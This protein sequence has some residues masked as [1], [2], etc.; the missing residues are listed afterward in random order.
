ME[1]CIPAILGAGVAANNTGNGWVG[2]LTELCSDKGYWFTSLCDIE[3]TF[4][5]PT[6]LARKQELSLSPYP[7]N[8]SSQQA[9]YFIE[10]VENI[11]IGDWIL[12]FNGE[13]VIGARQWQGNIID[14]PAMGDD[15]SDFTHGYIQTGSIP[16]FKLLNGDKLIDLTGDVPTWSENQIFMVSNLTPVP[17]SFKLS[18][19]Y[20]NPF[21]PTTTLSFALPL[22]SK[23]S[24]SIYDLQGREVSMLISGN[25]H[26]GYHSVVWDANSYASGMYFVKMVSGEFVKTQ[27]LMLVK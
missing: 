22:D 19:A 4:E 10:F 21:N 9:F 3:F 5:E 15:G 26:A 25:M 12:S 20:P 23:V 27:K 8:Q 16:T 18:A 1:D 13:T 17:E 2:S 24:L 6:S 14:V 11:E 7:Y